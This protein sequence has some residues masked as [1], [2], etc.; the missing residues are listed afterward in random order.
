MKNNTI[1]AVEF[2]NSVIKAY[3]DISGFEAADEE[4][5]NNLVSELAHDL[6]EE[7]EG[8]E[9]KIRDQADVIR[10]LEFELKEKDKKIKRLLQEKQERIEK[11][12]YALTTP[13]T[14]TIPNSTHP[15]SIVEMLETE[16][17]ITREELVRNREEIKFLRHIV[18]GL[19]YGR[20]TD[21]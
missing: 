2:V 21:S 15:A 1:H 13:K 6:S 19:V 17:E 18:E 5:V 7:M 10:G 16:M 20:K 3:V 9:R 14:L 8:M 4:E 11:L 12:E